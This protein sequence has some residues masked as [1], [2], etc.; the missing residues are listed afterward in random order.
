MACR[1]MAEPVRPG[2][3]LVLPDGRRPTRED[4]VETL[5]LRGRRAPLDRLLVLAETYVRSSLGGV[6]LGAKSCGGMRVTQGS[7]SSQT[8][9]LP[10]PLYC[11]CVKPSRR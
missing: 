10:C 3:S 2:R 9:D 6:D 7:F 8:A 5:S 4:R 1:D 11:H